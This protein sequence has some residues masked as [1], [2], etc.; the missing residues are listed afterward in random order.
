[1]ARA[2]GFGLRGLS[3]LLLAGTVLLC[4][5]YALLSAATAGP[6]GAL[7]SRPF[8]LPTSTL[9]VMTRVL[10]SSVLILAEQLCT[11]IY[12][13]PAGLVAA[14]AAA[15][16]LYRR[17][18]TAAGRPPFWAAP[19]AP[20]PPSQQVVL[21]KRIPVPFVPPV[22][23]KGI[24]VPDAIAEL[25]SQPGAGWPPQA[26]PA[27]P[28][29]PLTFTLGEDVQRLLTQREAGAGGASGA[30]GPPPPGAGPD[31]RLE[32]LSGALGRAAADVRAGG[33]ARAEPQPAARAA[34]SF[35]SGVAGAAAPPQPTAAAASAPV[36]ERAPMEALRG[37]FA[38]MQG[39]LREGAEQARAAKDAAGP[40]P[41]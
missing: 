26:P 37:R 19:R 29:Q 10:L 24:S 25:A 31:W 15:V 1:M 39:L 35:F 2:E 7:L 34:A 6:G 18:C 21:L 22:Y 20:P 11:A 9:L 33:A 38:S 14:A 32:G 36:G 5:A 28:K 12:Y 17:S 30:A 3:T 4:C 16:L 41:Q 13:M 8:A 23:Y 27:Q 40:P